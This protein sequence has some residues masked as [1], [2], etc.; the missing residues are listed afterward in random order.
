MI[1]LLSCSILSFPL[2]DLVPEAE[3]IENQDEESVI[4]STMQQLPCQKI[5]TYLGK[6][7]KSELL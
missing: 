3:R 2:Y 7:L 4:T 5:Y 1:S 6:E